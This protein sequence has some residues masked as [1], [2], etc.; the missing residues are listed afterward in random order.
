MAWTS[1]GT[2]LSSKPL[3]L[4]GPML[5]QVT[6]RSV[7]VWL[8]MRVSSTVTLTVRDDQDKFIVEGSRE[9]TAVG[10][11]LH[12]VAVTARLAVGKP[13]LAEGIVYQYDLT[14]L[15][16]DRTETFAGATSNAA[17]AYAPL[18]RP[19]FALPPQ[20]LNSLRVLQG[21]CRMPHAQ[22][23]DTL[24]VVDDLIAATATNAF[25]RPHQLLLTG[26]QI[27][28]DDV[29]DALL[30]LLI[31]AADALLGWQ[32]NLPKVFPSPRYATPIPAALRGAV[33]GGPASGILGGVTAG[34]SSEDLQSH[35]MS[36]GE[37]LAMYLFV[38]SD[39][40]WPP[41]L[42][43]FD[44]VAG[45]VYK[46][47][48]KDQVW[49]EAPVVNLDRTRMDIHTKSVAAFRT[50]LP[51][52]RRAL[53]NVP[54]YMVFD[55]H[56]VTDDWNMTREFCDDVYGS[57]IGLRI[58][59]N[60]LAAYALCQHWG[61]VPEQFERPTTPGGRLLDLLDPPQSRPPGV[62]KVFPTAAAPGNYDR[63]SDT[64]R[65][66]LAVHDKDALKGRLDKALYHDPDAF[67]YHFAVECDGHEVIF[68]DTRTWRAF[69]KGGDE[70]SIL[71]T[72]SRL[73]EQILGT[74]LG[75][76]AL[77]VVLSTNA[78]PVQPIRA[79]ARH[80]GLARAFEHFPDV[81]EAWEIPS[82]AFDN[83]LQVLTDK[84]PEVA[85][86][87][88][89]RGS[90][91]LLSGDVHHSFASRLVYRAKNRYGDVVARPATAV[92]GQLVA[93]SFK[94]E[95]QST[96]DFQ[97]DGYT[98]APRAAKLLDFIPPHRPEGYVGWNVAPGTKL[99]IGTA[100][101]SE[102]AVVS[103]PAKIAFEAPTHA[104]WVEGSGNYTVK[105]SRVPDYR[106]RL[107]YLVPLRQHRQTSPPIPKLPTGATQEERKEAARSYNAA[108][109]RYR[110][111]SR[112]AGNEKIIGV[113]NFGEITFDS[114]A[115]APKAALHTLRWFKGSKVMA[116]T[117]RISLDPDDPD[118]PD[119]KDGTN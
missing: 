50:T 101:L 6:P 47:I 10:A 73:V 93:S 75:N 4:A 39:V 35:L 77:L 66:I 12:I 67:D 69:P 108:H 37:Y 59:Q 78:P 41:D 36:L 21:S 116:T 52:V 16:A 13:R 53:A 65:R 117:Y 88:E 79:A 115:G 56:E 100:T 70:T 102:G 48:P 97:D 1:L 49:A 25:A 3:V 2:A 57:K 107:D 119:I 113:N 28:A 7:T 32:E 82:E 55:D 45:E 91:L 11:N 5:R 31:D 71:L 114:P 27:Y 9:T 105:L 64:I 63:N 110:T 54:T 72:K 19:S 18:K 118:F 51:Q 74:T 22:G 62:A 26:D 103:G 61:N 84:L 38:W 23:K 29:S 68:T 111:N 46:R 8:A 98:A 112:A 109:A 15:L 42:P 17:L 86:S 33:L 89:R 76:R 95:T 40:P 106:Y 24:P 85:G 83:L 87:T 60:A 43:S 44:D 96:R 30:T 94:K 20:D 58:V 81:Y 99:D 92:I 34:F 80:A 14:F 90:V 104:L